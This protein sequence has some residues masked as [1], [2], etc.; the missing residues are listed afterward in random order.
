MVSVKKAWGGVV[1]A[2]ELEDFRW[3]DLRHTFASK[4]VQAG[5]GLFVLQT[6]LGHSSSLMTQR[7]SHLA[8]D[9]LADAV[10]VLDK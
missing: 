5:V 10:A 4:L 1:E 9:H 8:P 3:H 6:L 2:A 7:Y